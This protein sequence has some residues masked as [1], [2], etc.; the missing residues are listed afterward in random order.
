[1]F[2]IRGIIINEYRGG[3][4]ISEIDIE[5]EKIIFEVKCGKTGL[6]VERGEEMR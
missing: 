4:A 3:K 1:M 2:I 5:I 6:S